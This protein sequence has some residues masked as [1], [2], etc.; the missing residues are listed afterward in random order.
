MA[1]TRIPAMM[2]AAILFVWLFLKFIKF[3]PEAG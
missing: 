2:Q 3:L 1:R